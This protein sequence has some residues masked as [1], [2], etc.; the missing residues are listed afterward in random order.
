MNYSNN[1]ITDIFL[2]QFNE[3]DQE[4]YPTILNQ[5]LLGL[6]I[7]VFIKFILD[8]ILYLIRRLSNIQQASPWL[9]KYIHD[10]RQ[11]YRISQDPNDPNYI[12][13]KRSLNEE[14][15]IEFT[16]MLWMYVNNWE[17]KKNEVKHVFHKGSANQYL[18]CP[19][20]FLKASE[21]VLVFKMNTYSDLYKQVE[22]GNIPVNKW[23][24]V[25]IQLRGNT[26]NIFINGQ[27]K[28]Y[29]LL[30]GIP[31]QNFGNIWITQN[32]GFDGYLSRFKYYDYATDLSEI[33][34]MYKLGSYS[35]IPTKSMD[36]PPYLH[37]SFWFT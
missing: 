19:G 32:G 28:K 33:E 12:P 36:Q 10:A 13:L 34:S 21:N 16:Y 5:I 11:E 8:I 35:Y 7:F 17:Y 1:L 29:V 9:I 26:L 4:Y 24:H 18:Q 2:G 30:G 14:S 37:Q 22:I 3:N 6:T 25:I 27:L 23:F 20:L 15:G 31:R